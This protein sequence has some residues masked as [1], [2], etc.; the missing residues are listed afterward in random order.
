MFY[1]IFMELCIFAGASQCIDTHLPLKWNLWLCIMCNVVT[2]TF[3]LWQ[4]RLRGNQRILD[5]WRLAG[6]LRIDNMSS[7][8][9][10][11]SQAMSYVV[12]V[13]AIN[14]IASLCPG[15]QL[16]VALYQDSGNMTACDYLYHFSFGLVYL[17]KIKLTFT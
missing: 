7:G 4:H 11:L 1:C 15:H 8:V 17:C 12:I 16:S 10:W 6:V 13:D 9:T 5:S 2:D 3:K 14:L